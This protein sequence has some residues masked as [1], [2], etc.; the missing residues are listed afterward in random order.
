MTYT[1]M[2]VARRYQHPDHHG[3]SI[4]DPAGGEPGRILRSGSHTANSIAAIPRGERW[5]G[6]FA[7]R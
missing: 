7:G 5:A 3:L 2:A 1:T 6:I 4:H